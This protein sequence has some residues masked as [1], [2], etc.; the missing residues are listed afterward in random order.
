MEFGSAAH[1]RQFAESDL[2]PLHRLVQETIEASYVGIYPDR[3]VQ[4]FRK[5]HSERK[6]AERSSAGEILVLEKDGAIVATGSLLGNEI[7]GVFVS[8]AAQRNGSGKAIMNELE[9][10]AKLK[11]IT[12]IHLSISLPSRQFYENMGYKVLKKK[13]MEVG[14]GQSLDYWPARKK[15]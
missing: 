14:D 2:V 13:S 1:I 10:R 9:K 11:G 6:I 8:P 3:A 7:L 5:Y 15:L 4:F 12:E